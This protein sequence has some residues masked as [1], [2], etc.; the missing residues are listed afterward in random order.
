MADPAVQKAILK[1]LLSLP[2]PVLRAMSGGGVVYQGGR[3]LDPRFQFLTAGARRMPPMSSLTPEEARAASAGGLAA[4]AGK[5]EPGVRVENLAIDGPGGALKLRAYRPADQDPA[6][7]LMVFAHFGGG[8]IGD[9]ETSD[10]FCQIL[11]RIAR[12]AVLSVDYRLAPEH[13]FPAAHDDALASLRWAFDHAAEIGFDPARVAVGGCSAGGNLSASVALDM[14]GDPARKLAFQLL[15]YPATAMI[16]DTASRRD[17]A[18]GHLL[19]AE[20]M[21]WFG[22]HLAAAGH[23]QQA[24][25]EPV[26]AD[27]KGVAPALVVTAGFD[28]LKDEGKAYAAALNAAGVKAEHVEYGAF[29]HDFYTLSP[30]CVAVPAAIEETGAKLK[31]ALA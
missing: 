15:L 30:F 31:A 1:V 8:V 26:N 9:L 13:P 2:T 22:N 23:P 16:Q 29:V 3:T 12:C 10:V 24:R 19:T 28:P 20:V 21:E 4:M 7:P 25:A 5:P 17:L 6:A 11:A 18:T 14:R 27:L